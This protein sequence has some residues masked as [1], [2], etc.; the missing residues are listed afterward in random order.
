MRFEERELKPHAEPISA[1]DLKEGVVYF[2]VNFIDDEMLFPVMEP[3][4]FVGRDLEPGDAGAVY[5]QD[6]DSYRK[7]V[8]YGKAAETDY[9]NFITGSE[10]DVHHFFEYERAL[11]TLMWCSVRRRKAG[12]R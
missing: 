5:F 8:R 11:E 4:V 2:S 6:M 3:L 12:M 10:K 9:A 7:G 1:L